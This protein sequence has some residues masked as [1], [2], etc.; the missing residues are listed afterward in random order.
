[1]ALLRRLAAANPAAHEPGL[2]RALRVAAEVHADAGYDLP[3]ALR[4]TAEA[5][6][7]Y[8]RLASEAPTA[9]G[10]QARAVAELLADLLDRA[11]LTDQADGLRD[12]LSGLPPA[13]W[14]PHTGTARA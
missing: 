5:A 13:D 3:W 4:M 7:I 12:V 2:A 10:G 1:M 11:G 14:S 6:E 9:H 8:T